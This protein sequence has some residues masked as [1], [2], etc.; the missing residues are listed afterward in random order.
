MT[1]INQAKVMAKRLS[2]VLQ[3][4]GIALPHSTSLEIIAA[5]LGYENWNV[6]SAQLDN[7]PIAGIIF[8]DY[9][10]CASHLRCA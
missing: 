8:P 5:E 9:D 6:A 7:D 10:P 4:R 1:T 2:E 3:A